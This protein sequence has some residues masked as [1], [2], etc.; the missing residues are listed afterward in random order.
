MNDRIYR[1]IS[2]ERLEEMISKK[3]NIISIP[4]NFPDPLEMLYMNV[5]NKNI[6]RHLKNFFVQCWTKEQ[7]SDA[8]W[9]VYS[10][11]PETPG[12]R[13]RTTVGKI[14]NPLKGKAK[15]KIE[16]VE[17]LSMVDF[18]K[19]RN[20]I[21]EQNYELAKAFMLKHNAFKYEKEIRLVCWGCRANYDKALYSYPIRPNN[22]IDQIMIDPQASIGK[23]EE[24]KGKLKAI[25]FPEKKVESSTRFRA[26]ALARR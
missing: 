7:T 21:S 25:R 19:R 5:L 12:V 3:M 6:D 23:F 17:Y 2:L 13:I 15:Y 16:E 22:V 9:Q 8:M 20:S 14:V 24:I 10:R 1:Y 11:T 26:R 4:A 18:R